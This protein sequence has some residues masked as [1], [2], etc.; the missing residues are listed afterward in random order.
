VPRLPRLTGSEVVAA[1]RRTGWHVDRMRGSHAQMRREGRPGTVTVPV[2]AHE[3][4]PPFVLRSI[5]TQA[6]LTVDDLERLR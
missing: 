6:G 2:H 4:L 1:L 3:V 5:L